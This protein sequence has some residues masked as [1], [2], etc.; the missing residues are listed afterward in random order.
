MSEISNVLPPTTIPVLKSPT[1]N[2]MENSGQTTTSNVGTS[3]NSLPTNNASVLIAEHDKNVTPEAVQAAIEAGNEMLQ[4]TNKNLSFQIDNA[5]KRVVISIIDSKTGE[6]IQQIPSVDIL[7]FIEAM[8]K[9]D[10][11]RGKLVQEKV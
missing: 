3:T 5:T 10:E 7:R 4:V 11:N 1:L 8:A 2:V 6:T 9:Q